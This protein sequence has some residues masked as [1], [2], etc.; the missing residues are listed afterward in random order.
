LKK[1]R[2][3]VSKLNDKFIEKEIESNYAQKKMKE[4]NEY[5]GLKKRLTNI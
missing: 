4:L 1:E 5:F 2:K 3:N